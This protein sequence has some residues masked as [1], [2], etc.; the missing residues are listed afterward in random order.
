M[1]SVVFAVNV[2]VIAMGWDGNDALGAGGRNSAL[3]GGLLASHCWEGSSIL[4]IIYY[5]II[6]IVSQWWLWL[7]ALS[8]T[9]AG[10]VVC[11]VVT[12]RTICSLHCTLL[13]LREIHSYYLSG[14][15]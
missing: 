13:H 12:V 5:Y 2:C 7:V 11:S 1:W 6:Y 10:C 9:A 4:C 14:K 15:E 3:R 8:L